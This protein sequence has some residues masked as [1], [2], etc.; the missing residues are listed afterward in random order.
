MYLP[1]QSDCGLLSGA[2]QKQSVGDERMF[3]FV[4]KEW[5]KEISDALR[6][7]ASELRI[8]CPFIK[9]GAIE[10]ILEH[11]PSKIQV[12]TRFNLVDFA[13]GVSDIEALR[14]LLDAGADIRG[15]KNLHA[16]IYLFSDKRAIVTSAN[17]TKAALER[18]HEFGLVAEDESLIK[19]CRDY[20]DDLWSRAGKNLTS[21]QLGKW[22]EKVEPHLH[23]QGQVSKTKELEN[24]GTDIEEREANKLTERDADFWRAATVED[25]AKILDGGANI[26]ARDEYGSTPLHWASLFSESPGIVGLLLDKGADIEARDKMGRTPLHVAVGH[27][28]QFSRPLEVVL[29]LLDRGANAETQDIWGDSPFNLIKKILNERNI[30]R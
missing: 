16:K 1:S 22:N 18:N 15:I 14:E 24:L 13:E 12:I 26:E 3:R 23:T 30:A 4:D 29:F 25:V 6:I 5:G 11:H 17:L 2:E 21:K 9:K 20:F 19:A 27:A 8:I 7:D 10:R 28:I